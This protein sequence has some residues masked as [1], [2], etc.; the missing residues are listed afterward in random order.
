LRLFGKDLT[1]YILLEQQADAALRAAN[2]LHAL[3]KDFGG[4]AE[5]VTQVDQIEHE[6]DKFTQQMAL[7]IDSSSGTPISKKDLHALSGRLDDITDYIEAAT[8]RI[9]LYRLTTVRPDL[10]PLVG[11]LVEITKATGEVIAALRDTKNRGPLHQ[12]FHG[13]HRLEHESDQIYRQAL[14][15][16]LNASDPDPILVIKW[17]E[18]YDSIELAIDKCED[19]ANVVQSILVKHS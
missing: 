19:A 18:I 15:T 12:S 2:T 17:K 5:Y 14:A 10:E 9:A 16:L 7:K 8:A 4:M 3:T 1:F 11:M 13:I 6:A